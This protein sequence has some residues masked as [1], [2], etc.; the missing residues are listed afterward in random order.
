[1]KQVV[2]CESVSI[3]VLLTD[4]DGNASLSQA[5]EIDVGALLRKKITI[6]SLNQAEKL[7]VLTNHYKPGADFA[8]PKVFMNGC[9]RSFQRAWLEKYPWL[10]Y[11]EECD[12]GFSLPCI[13]FSTHAQVGILVNTPFIRWTKVGSVCGEH[14]NLRY[15][16]N[17]MVAYE[18]FLSTSRN[19]EKNIQAQIESE[20]RNTITRNREMIKSVVKCVHFCGKQ[21]IALRGHRDDSS[22]DERSNKGNFLALLE[23]RIDA[24]DEP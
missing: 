9:N 5:R 19:P 23:F 8:F 13:F 3:S 15:H 14:E 22:A 11:S 12:G 16:V 10:V 17:A 18:N 20:R 24:G 6:K 21:C 7:N 4:K 2:H 1:M